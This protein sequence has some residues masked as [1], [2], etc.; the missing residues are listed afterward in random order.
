MCLAAGAVNRETYDQMFQRLTNIVDG[1]FS[2][3]SLPVRFDCDLKIAVRV[4]L[5]LAF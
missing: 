2:E 5:S 4:L 1:F 3:A